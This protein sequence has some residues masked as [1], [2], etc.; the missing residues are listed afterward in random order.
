PPGA[1]DAESASFAALLPRRRGKKP[2]GALF[3]PFPARRK[4]FKN[5]HFFQKKP[6]ELKKPA[7]SAVFSFPKPPVSSIP[8]RS[9]FLAFCVAECAVNLDSVKP[10]DKNGKF[11]R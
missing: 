5:T 10:D 7:I 8:L 11:H 2:S 3:Y 1:R 9:C 4:K 6:E